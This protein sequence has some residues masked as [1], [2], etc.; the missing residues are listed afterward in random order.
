MDL[1]QTNAVMIPA[2]RI[3]EKDMTV[4]V[5]YQGKR[6]VINHAAVLK[7]STQPENT[8]YAKITK[9]KLGTIVEPIGSERADGFFIINDSSE[10]DD[11]HSFT[12]EEFVDIY[13]NNTKV[14]TAVSNGKYTF[15]R[16]NLIPANW[17]LLSEKDFKSAIKKFSTILC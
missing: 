11:V 4:I 15:Y 12:I 3:E 16:D 10:N 13:L 8:A 1:G 6:T 14:R 5:T 7:N 17:Q 9:T 2:E